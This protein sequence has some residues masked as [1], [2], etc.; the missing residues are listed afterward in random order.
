MVWLKVFFFILLLIPTLNAADLSNEEIN[1]FKII[2]LNNDGYVSFD[3]VNQSITIIF[4][5][6]DLDQDKKISLD[7]LKELKQII[8]I[9][10]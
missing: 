1:Y 9:L 3:E 5:L 10:K 4:Q 8:Q 6:I 7:E 2:D